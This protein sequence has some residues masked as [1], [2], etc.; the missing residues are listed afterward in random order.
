MSNY[1]LA[2]SFRNFYCCCCGGVSAAAGANVAASCVSDVV[3]PFC[4]LMLRRC[5]CTVRSTRHSKGAGLAWQYQDTGGG[6]STLIRR[7]VGGSC[8]PLSYVNHVAKVDRTVNGFHPSQTLLVSPCYVH[9]CGQ[10]TCAVFCFVCVCLFLIFVGQ[11]KRCVNSGRPMCA[12]WAV[13]ITYLLL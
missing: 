12:F 1:W 8:I 11:A 9:C 4:L 7:K 5:S 3:T 6:P 13:F 10:G 2:P